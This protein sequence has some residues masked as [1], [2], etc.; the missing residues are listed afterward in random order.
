MN[1]LSYVFVGERQ[2]NDCWART[3]M[4]ALSMQY[5]VVRRKLDW[6]VDESDSS[7][8]KPITAGILIKHGYTEMGYT[9]ATVRNVLELIDVRSHLVV[10]SIEDHIFFTYNG[11]LYD[12]I[13]TEDQFQYILD[14]PV[15]CIFYKKVRHVEEVEKMIQEKIRRNYNETKV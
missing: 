15:S 5:G 14:K 7:L 2:S 12:N 13:E 3:L 6:L 4:F 10:V 11:I 8:G 9:N 1:K